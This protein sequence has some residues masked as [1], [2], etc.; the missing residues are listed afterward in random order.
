METSCWFANPRATVWD[1]F[2][3]PIR[4]PSGSKRTG[5][6]WK[7]SLPPWI[8]EAWHFVLSRELGLPHRPPS[9]LKQ[10]AVMAVPI[11]T[12]Q[13]LARLGAF[14]DDLRPFTVMTVPFPKRE[15]V[16]DPLWT[17]YFIMRH[18]HQLNDLHGRTMVNI[19]SGET[20][21]IYDKNSSKLPKPPGWLSLKTMEDEIN[22][23]LSRAESKFY[24]PNGGIC[25]PKTVG[26]LTRRHIVAGEFHY[27]RQGG[28]YTLG[29]WTRSVHVG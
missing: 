21:H 25:T 17:G 29:R 4:L 28:L 12:P 26:L 27:N 11:T 23:I 7:E 14:K 24:A 5:R 22:Q 9:W 3:P 13:V 6:K 16:S 18:T 2:G 8:Y 1:S 10:P 19:V 15:T 20:F